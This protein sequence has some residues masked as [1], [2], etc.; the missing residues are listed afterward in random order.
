MKNKLVLVT[1]ILFRGGDMEELNIYSKLL[2]VQQELRAPK[3]Q[4]NSFGNYNYRSCEDILEAVKPLLQKTGL[5]LTISDDLIQVGERY[6]VKAKAVLTDGKDIIINTAYAR[7]EETKKGMDGS[8][9]TGASSSYARK[10]ALNGLFLIDDVKDSDATN[11]GTEVTQEEAEKYVLNFGKYSGRLLKEVC[12]EDDRYI[13]WL[14]ESDK[15]D[16]TVKKCITLL[17]GKVELSEEEHQEILKHMAEINTLVALTG[18][19]F[20]NI[21]KHYEVKTT[22]DMTL[23]QLKDCKAVLE[24]KKEKEGK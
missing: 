16:A 17:T 19:D 9:I 2:G 18:A 20:D 6:Y 13:N 1:E 5:I 23:E 22:A 3:N 4:R 12:E 8:Q 21:L 10:Y 14:F 7:E 11:T 15:T 24:K